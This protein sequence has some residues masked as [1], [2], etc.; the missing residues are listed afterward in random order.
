MDDFTRFKRR[1]LVEKFHPGMPPELTDGMVDA[2]P[3]ISI[4]EFEQRLEGARAF[5]I[6]LGRG[7]LAA[8]GEGR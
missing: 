7:L 8:L 5:C 1:K 6:R 2:A 4:Q 3:E